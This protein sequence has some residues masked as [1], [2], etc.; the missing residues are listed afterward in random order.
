MGTQLGPWDVDN[1]DPQWLTVFNVL[2]NNEV[3]TIGKAVAASF[4][5]RARLAHPT[6]RK[7][8]RR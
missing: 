4:I 7:S 5:E 3:N 8:M 6:F 2:E 1:V